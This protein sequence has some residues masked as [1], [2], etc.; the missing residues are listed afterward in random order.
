[1][2]QLPAELVTYLC[3]FLTRPSLA[4]FRLT[5]RAFAALAEEHLFHDFEFRLYP[6]L[7]RLRQLE[8][9]AANRSIASRLRCITYE[10]GIPL[11]YADHRYWQAQVYQEKSSAWERSL[12]AQGNARDTYMEF[13][14]ALQARFTPELSRRYDLYR[15]H[16]D[17]QAA[18]MAESGIRQVLM[19][20]MDKLSHSS[21]ILRF[22][23]IMAE[24]QIQLEELEAFRPKEEANSNPYDPDPRRRVVNRRQHCLDHF[25]NF[26]DAARRS[27][28]NVSDLTAVDMPHQ[29]LTVDSVHGRQVLEEIFKG[30]KRLNIKVSEFPHSDWLSR[31]GMWEVY[32]GGRNLAAQRLRML[33]DSPSTLEHLSLEFPVG[34]EA[35]F[36]FELFD[37]TNLDRFPRSWLPRLKS[38]T[39]CHFR[40]PYDDLEAFL[41]EGKNIEALVLKHGRLENGAMTTLLDYLSQRRLPSVSLLGTWYVDRDCGEWHSHS[42]QDFTDCLAATSYEGP[43]AHMAHHQNDSSPPCGKTNL[44]RKCGF[45]RLMIDTV[46]ISDR[47]ILTMY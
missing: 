46:I 29:L 4:S 16:L 24:P 12:A 10:S 6:S 5:C 18:I 44:T 43:Y 34:R 36:S 40:S 39:L 21:P 22:K 25:I 27:R 28:C 2:D 20:A 45:I 35:E 1:M 33:L 8:E 31:G 41:A 30:L 47:I 3:Q 32:F 13:H 37:R 7:R 19:W 17:Q 23:L 11:E 42:E 14:E 9:L 15:W 38:L 26:L